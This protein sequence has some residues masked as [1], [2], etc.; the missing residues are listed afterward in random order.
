MP[1]I[2]AS[3][4]ARMSSSRFPGKIL[5]DIVGLPSLAREVARLRKSQLLND[6]VVATTD[7]PA[8]DAVEKWASEFGVACFRG[9]EDDVLQRVVNAQKFMNSDIVVEVCGDTP[10]IDPEVIDLAIKTY[11]SN[12]CDVVSNTSKLSFPQG[13]DAQV[14]S[15]ESLNWVAENISDS[16]VREHVSL[17]FYENPKTYR[18]IHLFAP[19]KW[20]SPDLRLQ[21]DYPEDHQFISEIFRRLEP[22]FGINFGIEEILSLLKQN[23]ELTEINRHCEEIAVR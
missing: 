14:F 12:D 1:R 18:I 3:I 22:E 16:A 17:H 8:D 2:V 23:P 21:M 13:L 9:S 11:Q 19:P 5:T 10:L 20:Q 15:L 4:E 7:S 6:I